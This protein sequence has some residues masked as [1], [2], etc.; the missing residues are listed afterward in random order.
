MR[1]PARVSML[2]ITKSLSGPDEG[3]AGAGVG[4]SDNTERQPEQ[5]VHFPYPVADQPRG[6]H[7]EH[8]ADE[9]PRQHLAYIQAGHD[10]LAGAGIVRQQ[11][12]QRRL[13]QHVLV[14]G[15]ALMRQRVDQR[16]FRSERGIEQ[17]PV[18]KPM[19]LG[20]RRDGGRVG[21]EVH[22]RRVCW[23]VVRRRLFRNPVSGLAFEFDDP[24]PS[25]LVRARLLVLPPVHRGVGDP[26]QVGQLPLSELPDPAQ[27]LYP[28]R[29]VLWQG[30]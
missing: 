14:H 3:I 30:G 22:A 4:T 21:C 16:G 1:S 2:V 7:D 20:D 11:E 17:M 23:P 24:P 25:Q 26:D 29:V 28:A 8:A 27:A 6:R 13:L 5:R 19:R 18:G 12:A 15:D 9:P 10:G